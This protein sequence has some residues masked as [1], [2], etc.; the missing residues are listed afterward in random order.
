MAEHTCMTF[1]S[2]DP[3]VRQ[4]GLGAAA[5]RY[6]QLGFA[7]LPLGVASKRPHSAFEHGVK[8][9]T[10]D[11]AMVPW[12]WSR[13]RLAGV[14]IA[15]GSASRLVVAD[16]DVKGGEDGP[17]A[18]G[19]WLLTTPGLP[20]EVVASTPSGGWHLYMRTPPGMVIPTRL[21]ILPGVDIKGDESYVVAAPSMVWV[22]SA[23]GQVRLPYRWAAGCPCSVPPMPEWFGHWI[24]TATATGAAAQGG[25]TGAAIDLEKLAAEG[26]P[27]GAR[28][29]ELH[30]VACLLFRRYG[31]TPVGLGAVREAIAP[32]LANTSR[33]G[34]GVAEVER[35][36]L[37]AMRFVARSEQAE[38]EA[39]HNR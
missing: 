23:Q 19:S 32:V 5:L 10:H 3:R 17:G 7:V 15:C 36:L 12:L 14:G 38:I 31:P 27:V 29:T 22:D 25:G 6:Q 30:R 21:G 33:A 24:A 26:L 37:S 39:W 35:I 13:D 1:R 4:L 28:N 34:F 11:P 20:I 2:D 16:L 9:A 8:Q 18:F